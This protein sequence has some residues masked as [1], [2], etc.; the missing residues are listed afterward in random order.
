MLFFFFVC[1]FFFELR[2]TSKL[3]NSSRWADWC[4]QKPRSTSSHLILCHDEAQLCDNAQRHT[5]PRRA[6]TG[7]WRRAA[8]REDERFTSS[9]VCKWITSSWK[10]V[11]EAVGDDTAVNGRVFLSK[12]SH[13]SLCLNADID[14][15]HPLGSRPEGWMNK[16]GSQ[17][18]TRDSH[19]SKWRV[20]FMHRV[21]HTD[22][23]NYILCYEDDD[24]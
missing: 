7:P 19:S 11:K 21:L 4:G 24:T 22:T 18:V 6:E 5:G 12:T 15:F 2:C 16:R 3:Q 13:C 8:R 10:P 20:N 9:S 17:S 1:V 14:I 23:I